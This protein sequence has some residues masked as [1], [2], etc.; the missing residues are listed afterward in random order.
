MIELNIPGILVEGES[1]GFDADTGQH[2]FASFQV[3]SRRDVL[4]GLTTRSVPDNTVVEITLEDGIVLYR[5]VDDLLSTSAPT[6]GETR[7]S[8][9]TALAAP[10]GTRGGGSY[11]VRLYRLFAKDAVTEAA[12]KR[13]TEKIEAKLVAPDKLLRCVTPGSLEEPGALAEGQKML[14]LLHGTFSSTEGSFGTL[15]P[16]GGGAFA[17][18]WHRMTG[19]FPGNAEQQPQVFGFEHRTLS[20][21]P[22]E[23]A[24]DLVRQLP[25]G[26]DLTLLSH[27]RGGLVGEALCRAARR[28]AGGPG[29]FF[30]PFDHDIVRSGHAK[31]KTTANTAI[32]ELLDQLTELD[33][34]FDEKSLKIRNFARVACPMRGTL[35]ASDR[36][37]LYLSVFLNLLTLAPGPQQAF[38]PVMGEFIRAMVGARK[39]AATLPGLEAMMPQ[40]AHVAMLNRDDLTL[41]AP[42][43]VI[44]GDIEA[45]GVLRA[46]AV[47]ASDL[48]YREDHDLVV[49]TKAMIG[50]A[51]RGTASGNFFFSGT[52]VSHFNYFR[53]EDSV[54]RIAEVVTGALPARPRSAEDPY[55]S[56]TAQDLG[57]ARGDRGSARGDTE[58]P[59]A[60][61]LPGIMGSTLDKGDDRIWVNPLALIN[62]GLRRIGAGTN[63]RPAKDVQATGAIDAY[64][65]GLQRHMTRTHRSLLMPYDWRLSIEQA[66]DDLARVVDHALASTEQPVRLICHSMGGLVAR[67]MLRK[68]PATWKRMRQRPGAR[69]LMLG[70]PNG[71][72]ASIAAG[73]IGR[74]KTMKALALLDRKNDMR[75][76]LSA[77]VPLPGVLELLPVAEDY[78]YFQAA[79]WEALRPAAPKG[80]QPP[81]QATLKSAQEMWEKMPFEPEDFRHILY[82]AGQ[83]PLTVTALRTQPSFALLATPNGDGRVT[84]ATGIPPGVATWYAP[85]VGHGDLP[86]DPDLFEPITELL[87]RG[88]TQRLPRTPPVTRDMEAVFELPEEPALYPAPEEMALLAM[89]GTPE[90][91]FRHRPAA[92]STRVGILHGDLRLQSGAIAVGHYDGAPL[93]SAEK[94][95]NGILGDTLRVH[96]SAGIYPGKIGT[97][98][99]FFDTGRGYFGPSA[100]LVIG[101]GQFGYLTP[102]DLKRTLTQALIRFALTQPAREDSPRALTSLLIGHLDSRISVRESQRA[103]LEALEL[104]NRRVPP[105]AR[106]AELTILELFEDRAIEASEALRDYLDTG[107]F[108]DLEIDPQLRS[109]RAGRIRQSFGRDAEWEMIIEITCPPEARDTL[110]FRVM[111]RSAIV[112]SDAAHVN[113]H[114]I[115]HLFTRVRASQ[116]TDLTTGL[117]LFRRLVPRAVRSILSEGSN[118]TLVL[119]EVAATYPWELAMDSRADDPLAI[120]TKMV[121][122]LIQDMRPSRPRPPASDISLVIG[123]PAS[124][125]APLPH[126]LEE[127][128]SVYARLKASGL[129]EVIPCL[130]G[131]PDI[132]EKLFLTEARL[133]HFAGHGIVKGG[134]KNDITGLVIGPESY[135]TAFDIEQMETVP[136]FVF[137]NCCHVARID[138]LK[139]GGDG[140]AYNAPEVEVSRAELAAN[141][142]I[143][144]LQQGCKAVI[145]AG[146]AI[147]DIYAK[148]F[149]DSFYDAFLHGCTFAEAVETA[150]KRTYD[151]A[152]PNADS[153]RGSDPTWGA[154]Q[155]YGDSQYRL[156]T[157]AGLA[158]RGDADL[159]FTAQSQVLAAL[160]VARSDA[161]FVRDED[162]AA[163]L[164]DMLD[165]VEAVVLMTPAWAASP[166]VLEAMGRAFCEIGHRDKALRYLDEAAGASPPSVSIETL[167]L[168]DVLRVRQASEARWQA[169]AQDLSKSDMQK[170]LEATARAETKQHV[171]A[172]RSLKQHETYAPTRQDGSRPS[173]GAVSRQLRLGD[174]H[175][176]FAAALASV[177][178]TAAETE[179]A[180]PATGTATGPTTGPTTD[181]AEDAPRAETSSRTGTTDKTLADYAFQLEEAVACYQQAEDQI[182]GV[183]ALDLAYARLRRVAANYF[184]LRERQE[185]GLDMLR[186]VDAVL[187]SLQAEDDT[188]AIFE[189]ELRL[190]EARLLLLLIE[191]TG[192]EEGSERSHVEETTACFMRAFY[193]GASIGQREETIDDLQVLARLLARDPAHAHAELQVKSIAQEL[194]KRALIPMSGKL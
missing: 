98:E 15:T 157:L 96:R 137:L 108:G 31:G 90:E 22:I 97:S 177:P 68:H 40:S 172:I 112:D 86:R 153:D 186:E 162:E 88:T 142:A 105:R 126:A 42:L 155:C 169:Q 77:I 60:I 9:P 87:M 39:D 164:R 64:Y 36:L 50:G 76:L 151:A 174:T 21:S 53:N 129:G 70:T 103:L 13:A 140:T 101:L 92:A 80:W 79:T 7:P 148:I 5:R 161:R 187:G 16:P 6:R 63:G 150:R 99:I 25:R 166:A 38:V 189:R 121:R 133:L 109:G 145:A 180:A 3:S 125:Y 115:D 73:L 83:A 57:T 29:T 181:T 33:R 192:Q 27:S 182:G 159:S 184:L 175:L 152:T 11:I 95:L 171:L 85:G 30:D 130:D 110:R 136:E 18:P 154:Y 84:W 118:V 46:L 58:K 65:R 170:A 134:P 19:A 10:S 138:P 51:P 178:G 183:V 120:R 69:I 123:D 173:P 111:N 72:S 56:S 81:R 54:A 78:R 104:A 48:F 26:A 59:V 141:V 45:G 190:A 149:A 37:D 71:G 55:I 100:A 193:A 47:F 158:P 143:A 66:A 185:L 116:R 167:E 113:R 94:A 191:N 144:F 117:L 17:G 102:Q 122:Q 1:K 93:I 44:S 160:H 91:S 168:R 41:D 20:K 82:I 43:D 34:L 114:A 23:N 61:I 2:P 74:D 139:T 35:L 132:E 62:G 107:R 194:R 188:P 156:R 179:K 12:V 67:M 4:P 14:L 147:D 119:D 131:D 52:Q 75:E 128:K 146:W 32:Q 124:Q 49:N 163:R 89:G 176:R 8:L 165:G 28:G 127:A 106:I 24:L 135:L